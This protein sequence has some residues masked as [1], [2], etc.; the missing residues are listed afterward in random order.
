V[1][2]SFRVLANEVPT[3][4]AKPA[5]LLKD[6]FVVHRLEVLL[7]VAIGDHGQAHLSFDDRDGTIAQADPVTG[8]HYGPGANGRGVGYIP[9][10][11]ISARSYSRVIEAGGVGLK[12]LVP[13]GGIAEAGGVVK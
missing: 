8:I 7:L 4:E 6:L 11:N 2:E 12:R 9:S 5:D 10:R 1:A 3:A 13:T